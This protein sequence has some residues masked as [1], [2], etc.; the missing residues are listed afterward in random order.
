MSLARKIAQFPPISVQ[1]IKRMVRFGEHQDL[2]LGLELAS[3]TLAMVRKTED[4]AAAVE[5]FRMKTTPGY[6]GR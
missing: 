5:A 4:H 3:S 2:R 1:A 6:I